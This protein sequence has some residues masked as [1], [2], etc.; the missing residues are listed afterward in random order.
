MKR[1]QPAVIVIGMLALLFVQPA[2]AKNPPK[3][4]GKTP[5]DTYVA[6]EPEYVP[7]E[8]TPGLVAP[9]NRDYLRLSTAKTPWYIHPPAGTFTH[10]LSSTAQPWWQIG[11]NA[12]DVQTTQF[13]GIVSANA[14]R[15]IEPA[16]TSLTKNGVTYTVGAWI[17]WDS[18]T[19]TQSKLWAARITHDATGSGF[20][21]PA[22]ELNRT[23]GYSQVADPVLASNPYTDGI[24]PGRVYLAGVSFNRDA[25]GN[26]I[27]PN[28]IYVWGSSDG[29]K[30]WDN[31]GSLAQQTKEDLNTPRIDPELDKPWIDVSWH[32]AT[33]GYVYVVWVEWSNATNAVQN[34]I[35][36]RRS[37][38]GVSRRCRPLGGICDNPFEPSFDIDDGTSNGSAH[39]PQVVVNPNNGEVYVLWVRAGR[40]VMSTSPAG[41]TQF[42]PPY[43]VAAIRTQ[44]LQLNPGFPLALCPVARFNHIT[45]K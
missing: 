17:D 41:G 42:G 2:L 43:T 25:S 23:S 20:V 11:T 30:T 33:R 3:L 24:G 36:F 22:V 27:N 37:T 26:S 8:P 6:S 14:S 35:R 45:N 38:N 32:P 5:P 15:P 40:I 7:A 9:P 29:G 19:S 18:I 1:N 44:A 28:A 31:G 12:V 34:K 39:L 10:R 16:L 4:K 13:R 21:E